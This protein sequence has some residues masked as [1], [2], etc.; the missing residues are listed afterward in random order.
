MKAIVV[1]LALLIMT[2]IGCLF[3]GHHYGSEDIQSKWDKQRIADAEATAMYIKQADEK[4]KAVEQAATARVNQVSVN[5][6]AKLRSKSNEK[7]IAITKYRADGLYVD[8]TCPQIRTS[9]M[10]STATASTS[11][12]GSSPARLSEDATIRL[13]NYASR[14]DK[15]V[16]TL[17]ALQEYYKSLPNAK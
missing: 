14:A 12:D 2:G 4:V 10:P 9:P 17:T 3:V 6:E 13:I 7:A 1:E 16:E 11:P 15:I 8:A 5:Y